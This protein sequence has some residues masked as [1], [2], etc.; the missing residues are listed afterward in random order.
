MPFVLGVWQKLQREVLSHLGKGV[1]RDGETVPVPELTD[2]TLLGASAT[3][4]YGSGV[5][6]RIH[7]HQGM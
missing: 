5:R 1:L 6:L 3:G 2:T 4:G 7:A